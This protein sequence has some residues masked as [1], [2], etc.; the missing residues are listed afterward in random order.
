M[1]RLH[2][3]CRK[4]FANLHSRFAPKHTDHENVGTDAAQRLIIVIQKQWFG[5]SSMKIG[6]FLF[7]GAMVA[8]SVAFAAEATD[9]DAK[10]RQETMD[11]IG[12]QM[13]VLGE[14]AGGKTAYDAAAAEAAKTALIAAATNIPVAFE[15]QGAGDPK[16][17][18]KPEIWTNWDDFLKDAEMLKTNA[19]ALDVSSVETIGAGMGAVGGVCKDCHTE[20]R[21]AN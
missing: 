7:V 8:A 10:A 1:H 21:M 6:K 15:K 20:Y 3:F 16:S 14:M 13:K 11:A 17:T 12:M 9:P 2:V 4:L 19:T 18:A 5:A